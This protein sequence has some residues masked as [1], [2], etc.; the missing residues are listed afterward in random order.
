MAG[1]SDGRAD[2]WRAMEVGLI[3]EVLYCFVLG[4]TAALPHH[5]RSFSLISPL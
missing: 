1:R 5:T 4:D 3:G 2:V